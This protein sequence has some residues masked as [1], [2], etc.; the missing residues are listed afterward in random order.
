MLEGWRAAV[1]SE[2]FGAMVLGVL[3]LS[4]LVRVLVGLYKLRVL[5]LGLGVTVSLAS[6]EYGSL[7]GFF[8]GSNRC[9]KVLG[10]LVVVF[11]GSG[12]FRGLSSLVRGFRSWF[13]SFR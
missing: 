7:Q 3:V 6:W 12:Q 10:S 5:V 8:S 2:T 4:G 9:P 13:W 11:V 1:R